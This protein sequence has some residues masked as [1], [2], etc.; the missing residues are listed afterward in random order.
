MPQSDVPLALLT[1]NLGVEA[2]QLLFV[3]IVLLCFVAVRALIAV[4]TSFLRT[5]AACMIGI[6]MMF[7]FVER[8]SS[9][10]A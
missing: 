9:F 10:V 5:A 2:G 1:F 7:W 8:L 4:R 6:L 3:V